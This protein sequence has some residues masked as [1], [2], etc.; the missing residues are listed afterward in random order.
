MLKTKTKISQKRDAVGLS[1][2]LIFKCRTHI[3]CSAAI[4]RVFILM[5]YA[6]LKIAT[7]NFKNIR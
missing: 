7:V 3:R 1:S 6:K 2:I 5:R 4:H